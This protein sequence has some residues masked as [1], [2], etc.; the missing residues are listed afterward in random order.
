MVLHLRAWLCAPQKR[1]RDPVPADRNRP[2]RS[3][4]ELQRFRAVVD[5]CVDS[6]YMVDRETLKFVDATATASSRT[7][8]SHE[9]LMRMGPLDLLKVSREELIRSY[10]AAIAAGAQGIRTE[11]TS[12]LKD[13]RENFRGVESPGRAHR[14][15]LDHRHDFARRDGAETA[16]LAAQRLARMFAALS[17]T[18]EAIMRVSSPEELV[19]TRVRSCG[20]RRQA[21]GG[22][23]LCAR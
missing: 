5:S 10:D 22:K 17:D 2:S 1:A 20:T 9:E 8:Y 3:L 13:G 11:S 7:G 6:I 19:S 18:N 14:R 21:Q 23:H 4:T 15:P 16:E 12:R